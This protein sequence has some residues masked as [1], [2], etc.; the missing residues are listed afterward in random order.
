IIGGG[1]WLPRMLVSA[2]MALAVVLMISAGLFFKTLSK[3]YETPLGFK[4]ENVLTFRISASFGESGDVA[5]ARHA[6]TIDALSSIPGV[7][8]VGM[9][10]GLP[11]TARLVPLEFR[12]VG[13]A[14][15]PSRQFAGQ[16][17]VTAGYFDTLGIS[18][19]E[20]ETCRMKRD[21]TE[22]FDAL[23]NKTFVD[24]FF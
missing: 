6:R 9:S 10:F 3:L 19:L 7:V 5:A 24:Q 8:A 11:A 16:R 18:I 2:Q 20:G 17:V 14:T 1:H 13:E 23:V 15:D 22:P 12:I 21:E 4:T